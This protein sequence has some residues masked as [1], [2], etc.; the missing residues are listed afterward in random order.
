M[1]VVY[2]RWGGGGPWLGGMGVVLGGL[3]VVPLLFSL[4]G[5]VMHLRGSASPQSGHVFFPFLGYNLALAFG[6][7]P[8]NKRKYSYDISAL[9]TLHV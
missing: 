3:V 5:G 1:G 2:G 4:R 9:Q 7:L 6:L 8:Q